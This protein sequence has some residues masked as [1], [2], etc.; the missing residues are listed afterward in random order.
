[1][2][3]RR[4]RREKILP[5]LLLTW[6][7]YAAAVTPATRPRDLRIPGRELAGIQGASGKRLLPGKACQQRLERKPTADA[8]DHSHER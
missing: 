5:V 8:L 6:L 4:R 2:R 3:K 1:M 7:A